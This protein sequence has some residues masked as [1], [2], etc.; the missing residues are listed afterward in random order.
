MYQK[1][2]LGTAQFGMNYGIS[3][4]VGKIKTTNITKILNFL[5]KENI[6]LI[7]TANNYK[8]SEKEIGKYCKKYKK[9]IFNK[10]LWGILI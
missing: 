7:D 9:K 2:V 1:I 8:K 4:Q 10:I 6:N 3:N 5:K